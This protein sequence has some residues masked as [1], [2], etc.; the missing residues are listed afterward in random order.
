MITFTASA[1]GDEMDDLLIDLSLFDDALVEGV[2]DFS[3]DLDNAASGTGGNISVNAIAGSVTTTIN[4]T[5]N[6]GGLSDGPA[7]WSI[8][9]TASGD[10][11]DTV[12][13]TVSLGSIFGAGENATVDISLSDI[14]TNSADYSNFVQAVQDAV[15]AYAGPGTVVFDQFSGTINW[16][17]GGDGDSMTDLVFDLSLSDDTLL[18]GS[19]DYSIDLDN[20]GSTTGAT[21]SVDTVSYTHLTLPTNRE[22]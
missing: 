13:Y 5:Q 6:A 17:A 4:D 2:E 9:G 1:D 3:I 22:V 15:D 7:Q 21:V 10:E 18:E 14:D 12:S 19:Q 20:S 11:G 16:T 8:T